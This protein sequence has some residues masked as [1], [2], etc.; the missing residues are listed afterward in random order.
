MNVRPRWDR[1]IS[2][3][4]PAAEQFIQDY[5][6]RSDARPKLL[7]GA[8]FD[9]RSTEFANRLAEAAGNRTTAIFFREQ[10]PAPDPVLVEWGDENER[11]LRRLIPNC[12]VTP[13]DIFDIDNASVGGRRAVALLD[14]QLNLEGTTDLI[15]DCSA[16]SVGVFFP[17]ARYC[18]ETVR[19]T[20]LPVNFHLVVLDQPATDGAI[21]ATPCGRASPLHA[22][23]G[24]L[25]LEE[26]K[27]AARL[28]LPQ[29]GPGR[30]EVLRLVHQYVSPHAVCPILPFPAAH[31]RSPDRLL[32]EYGD[33]F[34]AISSPFQAAWHVDARDLVFAH[35][36]SPLDLYR[37]ILRIDNARRRVFVQMGGS[38]VI[39]SP[40]GSKA[41]ALGVFMAALER[42]F[43][44]VSVES[45][46]Y[47]VDTNTLTALCDRAGEFVHIWLHGSAYRS[48]TPLENRTS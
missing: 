22:F 13:F 10:R 47:K 8:G 24:G 25:N 37:T 20:C 36:K 15:I 6:G 43:S 11:R 28:W 46:A 34:E 12:T 32:E 44:V 29:L 4:G 40:L 38:Q 17:L 42:D 2:H 39:L 35:E 30:R 19:S 3:R 5:F 1:C 27:D 14:S 48:A 26:H 45:I 7:A 16:L 21:E 33:L 31:P 9:P 18:Y 23:Q 41:L